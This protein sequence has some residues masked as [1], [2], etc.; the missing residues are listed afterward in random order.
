MW[1]LCTNFGEDA[2]SCPGPAAWNSLPADLRV[3]QE[4]ATFRRRLKTHVSH[5]LLILCSN[6]LTSVLYLMDYVM[7]HVLLVITHWH[8][9]WQWLVCVAQTYLIR[10][11]NQKWQAVTWTTFQSSGRLQ[12]KTAGRI[13]PDT[14]SSAKIRGPEN[15][16]SSTVIRCW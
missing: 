8:W 11:V 5:S 14:T 16:W 15:G 1:H 9:H 13:S 4:T 12:K 3:I 7:H 6:L 10:P 2:F